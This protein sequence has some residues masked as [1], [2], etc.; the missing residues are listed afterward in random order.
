MPDDLLLSEGITANMSSGT[1][2]IIVTAL[3]VRDELRSFKSVSCT[4]NPTCTSPD[5]NVKIAQGLALVLTMT[6]PMFAKFQNGGMVPLEPVDNDDDSDLRL[7]PIRWKLH[8]KPVI[9]AVKFIS[10]L[11]FSMIVI[12][13]MM[14]QRSRALN[15]EQSINKLSTMTSNVVEFATWFGGN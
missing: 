5:N 7:G 3:T 1:R 11:I 15:T 12:L 8:G 2:Q 6:A 13:Y 14:T 9:K 4:V 10:V